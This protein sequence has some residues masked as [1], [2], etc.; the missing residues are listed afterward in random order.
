MTLLQEDTSAWVGVTV[1]VADA[2]DAFFRRQREA[3]LTYLSR[4]MP[5][6]GS[7]AAI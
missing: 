2:F 7:G 5:A 4:R 6:S 3:V 1:D